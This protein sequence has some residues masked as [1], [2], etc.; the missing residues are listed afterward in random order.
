MN[1]SNF[2]FEA[3][4]MGNA[5]QKTEMAAISSSSARYDMA[6]YSSC[7]KYEMAAFSSTAKYDADS[8]SKH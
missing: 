5:N 3:F 8:A 1:S 4:D 7:A 6:A 2:N